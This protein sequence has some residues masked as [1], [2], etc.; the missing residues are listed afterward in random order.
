[1]GYDA[2]RI[3]AS[4][5]LRRRGNVDETRSAQT[6]KPPHSPSPAGPAFSHLDSPTQATPWHRKHRPPGRRPPRLLTSASSLPDVRAGPGLLLGPRAVNGRPW[7]AK[8]K[9]RST[10]THFANCLDDST[11][12]E[13][14]E[15]P[16]LDGSAQGRVYAPTAVYHGRARSDTARGA[17]I[18]NFNVEF[19]ST[20]VVNASKK[21]GSG[22]VLFLRQTARRL[23]LIASASSG[24]PAPVYQR[25]HT[26]SLAVGRRGPII[27]HGMATLSTKCN[28]SKNSNRPRW[29]LWRA[30]GATKNTKTTT[31]P[32]STVHTCSANPRDSAVTHRQDQISP[33]KWHLN[34]TKCAAGH[35]N[36]LPPTKVQS[37]CEI[38]RGVPNRNYV[39]FFLFP[40]ARPVLCFAATSK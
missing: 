4:A 21:T 14:Q 3:A 13:A 34:K 16:G 40:V 5:V 35:C 26:H 20:N 1:L 22:V 38:K 29:A 2:S 6:T 39:L 17:I 36:I 19:H 31:S 11:T 15:C 7:G 30:T 9:W 33:A 8:P 32:L 37:V 18:S 24:R 10:E 25:T 23:S 28:R 12:M 27:Q